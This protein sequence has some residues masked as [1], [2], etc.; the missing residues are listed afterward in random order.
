MLWAKYGLHLPLYKQEI[1]FGI[2]GLEIPRPMLCQWVGRRVDLLFPIYEAME[3]DV[4]FSPVL[5]LDDSPVWL[6]GAR[7]GS[8]RRFGGYTLRG[9]EATGHC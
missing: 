1:M 3:R 2:I 4:L 9:Q 6:V 5:F 7:F 8:L